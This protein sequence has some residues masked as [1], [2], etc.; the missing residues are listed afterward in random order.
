MLSAA[1]VA[2][3]SNWWRFECTN[4]SATWMG[5]SIV[6]RSALS[7]LVLFR[8]LSGRVSM[9]GLLFTSDADSSGSS[10]AMGG[11]SRVDSFHGPISRLR[12]GRSCSTSVAILLE[13]SRLVKVRKC[14]RGG[15]PS[16][17]S[18]DQIA[19]CV[20]RREQSGVGSAV[21]LFS[22]LIFSVDAYFRG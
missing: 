7:W 15:T 4:V 22:M 3:G 6:S 11:S 9:A 14:Q 21:E 18:T 19:G 12:G 17:S 1:S 13:E 2:T 16:W 5:R 10:S 8:V 20:E